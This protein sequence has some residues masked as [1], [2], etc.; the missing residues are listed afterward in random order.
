MP[1]GTHSVTDLL[2]VTN[3]SVA[4]FG[5]D[6][7][8][9]R[10]SD[11][12]AAHNQIMLEQMSM[13]VGEATSDRQRRVGGLATMQMAEVDEY[14]RVDAQK[15]GT[16]ATVGFPLRMYAISLQWTRKYLQQVTPAELAAQVEATRTA[17]VLNIQNALRRAL[18][19]PTNS[20]FTDRLVDNVDLAVKALINADSFPIGIGPNGET[21][22]TSTHT[23]YIAR[24]A[25][26]AASDVAAVINHVTEHYNNGAIKLYINQAQEAAIRAMTPNFVAY[27]D[28]RIVQGSANT[29]A[30]GTLDTNNVYNRAIGLFN[31]AEVVVKPWIPANYMVAWMEGAQKP[32]VWRE[33]TAGSSALVLDYDNETFPLRAH[34]LGREFGIGVN[35]RTAAAVL[36]TGGTGY[37]TPVFA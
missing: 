36:F 14:G 15:I 1:Y 4:A 31:Q 17:D 7:T 33:R 24:V 23:H 9:E 37:V 35:E 30:T 26:L 16:G 34:R 25:A 20:T 2:T 27:V 21:F 6:K 29:F 32:L 3:Q 5:E 19:T 8:F 11:Y 10:I 22:D 13:L 28:A 18:F 12:L